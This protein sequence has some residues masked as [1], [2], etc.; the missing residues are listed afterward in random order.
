[1]LAEV[2]S[3]AVGYLPP[4]LDKVALDFFC[5]KKRVARRS[6]LKNRPNCHSSGAS[7]PR[8]R[9]SG[10]SRPRSRPSGASRPRRRPSARARRPS[11]ARRPRCCSSCRICAQKKFNI[12]S[13][14]L[15]HPRLQRGPSSQSGTAPTIQSPLEKG[16]VESN[17]GRKIILKYKIHGK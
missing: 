10:A 11:G 16:S 5:K 8:R 2:A 1:M 9:P 12:Q 15:F 3:I 4:W 6:T 13:L 17:Q 14:W 7:R